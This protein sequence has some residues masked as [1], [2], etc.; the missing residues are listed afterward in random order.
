MQSGVT[1][2]NLELWGAIWSYEVQSG[3]TRCNLELRGAIWSYG[4]QSGVMYGVGVITLYPINS[5]RYS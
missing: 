2:C 1:R 4:V 5:S 3:V